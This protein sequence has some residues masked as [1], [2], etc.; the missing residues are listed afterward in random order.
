MEQSDSM[1]ENT[2][3]QDRHIQFSIVI[4]AL[5]EAQ[6]INQII[7]TIRS[8]QNGYDYEIIVVDGDPNGSTINAVKDTQV[9][10]LTSAT[11]RAAQMNTGADAA[12]GEIVIFLHADTRLPRGAL[13]KIDTVFQKNTY[14]AGAFDLSIDTDNFWLRTIAAG[15]RLRYRLTRIPYGDQAIFI[16][17]E[18]FDKI[19]KYK[20]IPIMEDVELMQRIRKRSDKIHILCDRITTSP[21]RWEKE[22]ILYSTI[23][24]MILMILFK[25]GVKP[26]KLAK[27]Y[28]NHKDRN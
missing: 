14:S 5:N 6:N 15:S 27:Y 8:S 4:P 17:K 26:E 22:G 1:T 21:R 2:A 19:G 13:K 9:I 25:F 16:K 10:K 18:Y 3:N 7:Q 20:T 23:R 11:G 24:N 28:R 12:R